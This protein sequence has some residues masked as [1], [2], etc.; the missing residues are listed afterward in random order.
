M[1]RRWVALKSS[2]ADPSPSRLEIGNDEGMACSAQGG[3]F[4]RRVNRERDTVKQETH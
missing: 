4:K 1:L 2:G 3:A